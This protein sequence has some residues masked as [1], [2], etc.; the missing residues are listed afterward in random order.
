MV[1]EG[2]P[3][4][5][6]GGSAMANWSILET[7]LD[8]GHEVAALVL[9]TRFDAA[10]P[11]RLAERLR[12]LERRGAKVSTYPAPDLPSHSPPGIAQF[13][14]LIRPRP[15]EVYPTSAIGATL[16]A[17][18]AEHE[19]EAAY[20]F[21][22]GPVAAL[23]ERRPCPAYAIFGDP[24]HL[25]ARERLRNELGLRK[26]LA[27]AALAW[28]GAQCVLPRWIVQIASQYEACGWYGAQHARWLTS[29]GVDCDYVPVPVVDQALLTSAVR[30]KVPRILMLSGGTA[31]VSGLRLLRDRVL[32][33]L[34]D[35]LGTDGYRLDLAGRIPSIRD[36]ELAALTSHPAVVSHG[37]VDDLS[38]LLAGAEVFLF[39]SRYP[40]GIRTRIVAA[41]SFGCCVVTDSSSALGAPELHDGKNVL[42][43]HSTSDLS[44]KLVDA[45]TSPELR[46]RIGTAARATYEERFAPNVAAGRIVD[47]L[48]GLTS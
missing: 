3:T 40:V 46:R 22:Y 28:L 21:D 8:R 1:A 17:L 6:S 47:R 15:A 34:D 5:N 37:F 43:A 13:R 48:V 41:M 19:P 11:E 18:L 31:S 27:R 2:V 44:A 7:A 35:A 24:L 16:N 23:A 39:P 32:P 20:V 45:L 36:D 29:V 30:P 9:I 33:A 25:V 14:P 12:A 26:A 42:M 38:H 4:P 10:E